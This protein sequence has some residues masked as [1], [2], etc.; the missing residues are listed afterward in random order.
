MDGRDQLT[1]SKRGTGRELIT[2]SGNGGESSVENSDVKGR[3][4]EQAA[5]GKGGKRADEWE[6]KWSARKMK[7]GAREERKAIWQKGKVRAGQEGVG[8][9]ATGENRS[10]RDKGKDQ[11]G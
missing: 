10:D 2:E 3:R 8:S 6:G 11:R 9:Q 5:K 7:N 4:A 1:E